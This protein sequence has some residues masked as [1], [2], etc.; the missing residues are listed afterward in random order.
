MVTGDIPAMKMFCAEEFSTYGDARYDECPDYLRLE[1]AMHIS[2][3]VQNK[4]RLQ[5]LLR[6]PLRHTLLQ[7]ANRSNIILQIS[8]G[9]VLH[10]DVRNTHLVPGVK[11]DK[12]PPVL[13]SS[14]ELRAFILC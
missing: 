6:Y 5:N 8:A 9:Q 10:R 11:V 7:R 1:I 12:Q 13:H 3:F 2:M 4:Q 14:S